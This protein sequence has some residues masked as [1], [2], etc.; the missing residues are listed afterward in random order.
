MAEARSLSDLMKIRLHNSDYLDSVNANLGTALGFK[1]NTQGESSQTPAILVFV[2]S[3]INPKWIPKGRLLP[4]RLEGPDELWC[5]LDVVESQSQASKKGES[6]VEESH[7]ELT[8]RLR[9]WD[10]QVWAGSQIGS[11]N[12]GKSRPELGTIAAFV[13][14]Q[15]N[16]QIGILTNQHVA[17]KPESKLFHPNILGTHIATTEKMIDTLEDQKWYSQYIDEEYAYIKIDCAFAPI[18]LSFDKQNINPQL[19][20]IGEFGPV[21]PIPLND[22]SIIG[23]KVVRVGRTTGLRFGTIVAYG[24]E[25]YDEDLSVYTDLL[26]V[27]DDGVPFST[28]GDSGS[29]IVTNDSTHNPIGLLWGGSER[30]LRTG[31][32]RE[33][34]TY[35]SD[36]FKVLDA[37]DVGLVHSVVEMN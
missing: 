30:K 27:G 7:D 4:K 32:S 23:R 31:Y 1:N 13:K 28:Y 15:D 8:E 25:W 14:K 16:G 17:I 35:A 37:L 34:W 18:E 5:S 2:P 3:K 9:G 21:K 36:L 12:E 6:S 29:L 11:F 26:I 22:M 24:Y 19:M 10:D 20:G 33:N